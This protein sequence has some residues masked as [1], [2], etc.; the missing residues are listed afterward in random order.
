MRVEFSKDFAKA[1]RRLSGKILK[2]VIMAI[3]E[4]RV[5]ESVEDLT[6]CRK[7]E[8]LNN[9]YRLRIGDRRAFLCCI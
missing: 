6:N 8:T 2:S 9:V 5:A 3:D 7:I 1:V 4:V